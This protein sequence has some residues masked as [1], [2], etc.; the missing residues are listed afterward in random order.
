MKLSQY[1]NLYLNFNQKLNIHNTI[2]ALKRFCHHDMPLIT[3]LPQY[4]FIGRESTHTQ[5][6]I[7]HGV[8]QSF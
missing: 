8:A 3:L 5:T 7:S 1:E 6:T 4:T 2:E